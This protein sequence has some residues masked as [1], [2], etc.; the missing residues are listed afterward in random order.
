MDLEKQLHDADATG[1]KRGL[2][3]DIK[4]TWRAPIVNWVFRTTTA[5]HPE[6]MRYVWAQLKPLFTTAAFARLTVERRD[7][8][9]ETVD[10][11][12]PVYRREDLDIPPAE[13]AELHGQLATFDIVS[14]RLAVLFEAGDRAMNRDGEGLGTD[15]ATDRAATAPFPEW[16]DRDRG[17][18]PTMTDYTEVP[19]ELD[20][21]IDELRAF[22]GFGEGLPS[23]YRCLAQWPDYLG[24]AW[25]DIEDVLEGDAY[26]AGRE[27]AEKAVEEYVEEVPYTPRLAPADMRRAGLSEDAIEDVHDLFA[28]FNSGAVNSV[29]PAL[30][31]WAATLDVDGKRSFP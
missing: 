7:A 9:L 5:N 22:H 17:R 19:G 6:A 18:P 24:P 25:A 30:H 26:R 11:D 27:R 13:F 12:L 1:W 20:A 31:V 4:T 21:T 8:L 29:L 10:G 28:D 23:I 15:P 16:L 3:D 2:Y 14:P